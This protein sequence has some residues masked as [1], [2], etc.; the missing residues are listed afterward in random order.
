MYIQRTLLKLL[1]WIITI[2]ICIIF[3]IFTNMK[4]MNFPS[5]DETKLKDEYENKTHLCFYCFAM[6]WW[7]EFLW[8]K[9][10]HILY[11]HVDFVVLSIAIWKPGEFILPKNVA[12]LKEQGI[13]Q[14]ICNTEN[15]THQKYLYKM[16]YES[17]SVK[18]QNGL[19]KEYIIQLQSFWRIRIKKNGQVSETCQDFFQQNTTTGRV[20]AKKSI[21]MMIA[22]YVFNVSTFFSKERHA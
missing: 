14:I 8:S 9:N 2:R 21:S 18:I 13:S 22:V 5:F 16:G 15:K 11:L 4:Y 1:L 20:S 3:S 12:M 6:L 17:Q 10:N 7:L 19:C